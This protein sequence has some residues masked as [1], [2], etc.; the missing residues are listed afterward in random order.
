MNM[1]HWRSER[2]QI[3]PIVAA[4]VL[5]IMGMLAVAG[6]TGFVWMQRRNMRADEEGIAT[7]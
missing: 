5:F 2:G 3:V 1:T 6:D 7:D 4:M